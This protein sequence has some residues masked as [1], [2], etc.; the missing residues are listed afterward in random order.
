MIE[1]IDEMLLLIK[2]SRIPLMIGIPPP[3][4]AS[5]KTCFP[6]FCAIIDSDFDSATSDEID[7]TV[8]GFTGP[9]STTIEEPLVFYHKVVRNGDYFFINIYVKGYNATTWGSRYIKIHCKAIYIK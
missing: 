3:T 1:R 5:K 2:D 4:L 8:T 6:F 7:V 9:N